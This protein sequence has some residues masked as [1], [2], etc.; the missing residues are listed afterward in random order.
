[1]T[2]LSKSDMLAAN[3]EKHEYVEVPEWGGTVKIFAMS[4]SEH[5]EFEKLQSKSSGNTI[6]P[7]QIAFVLSVAI[8]DEEGKRLFTREEAMSLLDK[9][10]QVVSRLFGKCAELSKVSSGEAGEKEKN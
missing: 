10:T 8:R 1:M 7:D 2:L 5:I 6:D 3:D 4:L 9:N